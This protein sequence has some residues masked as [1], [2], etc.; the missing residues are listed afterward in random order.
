MFLAIIKKVNLNV[1]ALQV[2]II[3]GYHENVDQRVK[4]ENLL[5]RR[6][7]Y[8]QSFS[9]YG[10][11][12]GSYDYGPIGCEIKHNL[13]EEW[14]RFFVLEENMLQ[15]E[16]STIT[17]I[18]VMSASGHL[19]RFTDMMVKDELTEECYRVDHLL[20]DKLKK[21]LLDKKAS[22]EKKNEIE[23]C[24]KRLE[25]MGVNEINDTISKYEI[26]APVTNNNLTTAIPFNLMFSTS[27]GPTGKIKGFAK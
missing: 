25:T 6:F 14:R 2:R 16:C 19:T 5:K 12:S 9:I 3:R 26:K 18:Q 22:V 10:G 24:L 4:V 17:P 23:N 21:L 27:I 13:L 11:L 7:V 8:D 20:K 15:V 1:R